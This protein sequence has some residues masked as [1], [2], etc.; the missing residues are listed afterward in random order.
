VITSPPP[1]DRVTFSPLASAWWSSGTSVNPAVVFSA[2][3]LKWMARIELKM[4]EEIG[5]GFGMVVPGSGPGR[6]T[7]PTP[8][9]TYR[10]RPRMKRPAGPEGS[11][12]SLIPDGRPARSV[13]RLPPVSTMEMRP[14]F[15]VVVPVSETSR[16]P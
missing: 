11:P 8:M 12:T 3:A 10:V 15:G 5:F 7:S 2:L 9:A 13:R 6:P 1:F 4:G 16:L 14:V